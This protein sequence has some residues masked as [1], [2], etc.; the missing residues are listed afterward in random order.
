MRFK[1][2]PKGERHRIVLAARDRCN[3]SATKASGGDCLE[4]QFLR[5]V[6]TV[7]GKNFS[8]SVRSLSVD[9]RPQLIP[10]R[11]TTVTFLRSNKGKN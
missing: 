4:S 5:P 9:H 8:T 3:I 7:A 2:E 6:K 10:H 11:L 1:L